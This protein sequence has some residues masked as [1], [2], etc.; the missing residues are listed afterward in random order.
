MADIRYRVMQLVDFTYMSFVGILLPGSAPEALMWESLT[1]I[2]RAT[3]DQAIRE[4]ELDQYARK[5]GGVRFGKPV[6]T[7]DPDMPLGE[8]NAIR[9][10]ACEEHYKT[11]R[12]APQEEPT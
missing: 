5:E 10:N 2:R 11:P 3:L 12:P 9:W 8:Q 7:W 1:G 6:W 4:C